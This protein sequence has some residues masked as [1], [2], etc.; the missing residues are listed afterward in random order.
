MK[1]EIDSIL[2]L[3]KY[4]VSNK[5]NSDKCKLIR[6]Y[7]KTKLHK[8]LEV[9]NKPHFSFLDIPIRMLVF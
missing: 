1:K 9:K 8:A 7:L 5:H 3:N 4:L 6:G 2:L